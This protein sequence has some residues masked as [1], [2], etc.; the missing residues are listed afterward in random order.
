MTV[1]TNSL[2]LSTRATEE[3]V[4]PIVRQTRY[5]ETMFVSNPIKA[6]RAMVT[7]AMEQGYSLCEIENMGYGCIKV[8]IPG[9][10]NIT[11][12]PEAKKIELL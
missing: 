11:L 1:A 3:T 4:T 6:A 2:D 9:L 8:N 7:W 5:G 12:A 10:T